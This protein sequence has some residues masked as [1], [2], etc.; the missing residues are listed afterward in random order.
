MKYCKY[1]LSIIA[2]F[3]IVLA[4]HENLPVSIQ[5]G[6]ISDNATWSADSVYYLN[7]QVFVKSG[8]TLTIEAGTTILGKYDANYSASNPA[9]VLVI[10]Q[11]AKIDAQGT[12]ANPITFRSELDEDDVSYGNGRGLWGGVIVLGYAPISNEGGTSNVEGLTGIPYGGSDAADNSGIMKYVR[13]WNGGSAIAPDNEINGL[14]LA[15]V[16]NGTTIEYCEV[17][18]NLDDG[19]EMFGGTVDLKYCS[20]IMVGDDAFDTDNGYQGRGQFLVVV[21][22][23]FSDKSHEMDNATGGDNDSQPRSHPKFANVTSIGGPN[24][25][26]HLRLREG[27]GG[28]FRNYLI[29]GGD[30]AFR[31]DNN[32][33]E[34]ITQDISDTSLSYPDYLYI[35]SNNVA[36]DLGGVAFKD[37]DEDTDDASLT[38]SALSTDP[39]LEI[40]VDGQGMVIDLNLTPTTNGSAFDNVDDVVADDFFEQTTFKGAI[41][42]VDWLADWSYLYEYGIMTGETVVVQG[43]ITSDQ[44]WSSENTY[45]LNGQTF[46]KDGVTLTI[47]PGTEIIGRYDANYNATNPAP[48]LVIEQGA[49]IDAVGTADNPITFRSELQMGDTNYGNGRGLWGGIIILGKAP[50][51]NEGGTSNIEGLTGVPYG[52]NDPADNSGIMKY[53]RI[54]NGGCAIAADNEINGLT[55]GGVGN[56]TTIEYVEV[57]FNLDDGFEMFGG[58]VNLKYCSAVQVGDDSFDT[59]NGYQ[60]KGQFLFV[61]RALDSD[62][63]HEM[64]NRTGGDNDSQPRSFP[65]FSNVTVMGGDTD[66]L[67]LRE[68]TGGDFRNYIMLGGTGGIRNDNNGSEDVTQTIPSTECAGNSASTGCDYLYLSPNNVMWDIPPARFYRDVEEDYSARYIDTGIRY[69]VDDAGFIQYIRTLPTG[70]GAAFQNVD[71]PRAGDT[72]FEATNFKGAF[73]ADQWLKG[74]SILDELGVLDTWS[75]LD[76]VDSD[77]ANLPAKFEIKGNYPNPFNPSTKIRFDIAIQSKVT[78]VIYDVLGHEIKSFNVGIKR[79]GTYE[80]TWDGKNNAGAAV[81][82]GAYIY[83][84]TSGQSIATGKM[85][86]MR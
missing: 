12:A 13:I 52:G 20:A 10:E 83:N 77:G 40:V 57:A 14:T 56:G 7:D 19:F 36:V 6:N 39:G 33:S 74:W 47:Q 76:V 46:V 16:G 59:D 85:M 55:M 71:S 68:G 75:S 22:G 54:W 25:A 18:L 23:D 43:D 11:G 28:D 17:A 8:A 60:G 35:S 32:G 70:S 81:P 42:T 49:K 38:F 79:P 67:R 64:D 65:M 3:S 30:D 73:G 41:G 5:A 53:V 9:P 26:D 58:T 4:D 51:S 15:G 48:V 66:H 27:T 29:V 63:S 24:A 50:I 2:V 69:L 21:K 1:L 84:V 37:F 31:N 82:S 86:L 72:F 44:T 61:A 80:L 62:K 78:M 45:Y 34:V